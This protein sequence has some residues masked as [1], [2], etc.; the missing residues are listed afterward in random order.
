MKK[1]FL[2]MGTVA[3]LFSCTRDENLQ[4][5]ELLQGRWKLGWVTGG[6]TGKGYTPAFN[7]LHFTDEVHY[8]LLNNGTLQSGGTYTLYLKGEEDWIRFASE[9]G[10]AQPFEAQE[11]RVQVDRTHLTLS[12]PCCDQYEYHFDK[13]E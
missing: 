6:I 4:T 11:K 3:M 2:W 5:A 1:A 8:E 10:I 13:E 9:S 7:Q 12:E